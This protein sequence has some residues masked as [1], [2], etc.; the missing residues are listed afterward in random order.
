MT[1]R[2]MTMES[3]SKQNKN[4]LFS[5]THIHST[6]TPKHKLWL[7]TVHVTEPDASTVWQL[8][9]G[10]VDLHEVED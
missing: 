3:V 7:E 2:Y 10:M 4:N 5:L 8:Q 1:P 6:Y 9:G